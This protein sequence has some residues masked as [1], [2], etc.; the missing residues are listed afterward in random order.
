LPDSQNISLSNERFHCPEALFKPSLLSL[1]TPGVHKM[2]FNSITKCDTD[3]R[4]H[5]FC[6]VMLSGGTSQLPGFR[7]RVENE[8]RSMVPSN[9]RIRTYQLGADSMWI[10]GSIAAS[11]S[12]F[13][14]TCISVKEYEESGAVLVHRDSL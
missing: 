12:T 7:Q 8:I 5:Y 11:L 1:T 6:N 9:V 10:G 2:L 4:L 14:Q 13:R 3:L